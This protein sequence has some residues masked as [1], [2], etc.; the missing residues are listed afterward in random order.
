MWDARQLGQMRR[1]PMGRTIYSRAER[2]RIKNI[3]GKL[4]ESVTAG[5]DEI[6]NGA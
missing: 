5:A 1:R 4:P 2:L 3:G 6:V